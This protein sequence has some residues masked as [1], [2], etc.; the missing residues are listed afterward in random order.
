MREMRGCGA[1]CA[2]KFD[3]FRCI[4]KMVLAPDDM[5]DFHFDVVDHIH[6]VKNPRAVGAADRHIGMGAWIC[7]IEID[8]AADEV[9]DHHVLT[10]RAKTERARI[11][12]NVATILKFLQIA[13][14]NLRSLALQ[15]RSHISNG[16]T[17]LVPIEAKPAQ[18]FIDRS[19]GLFGVA[20]SVGVLDAQNEFAAMMSREEPIK[21]RRARTADMEVTSG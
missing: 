12:E 7:E 9:I 1:E 8:F 15:I 13:F 4:R 16:V 17:T 6:E 20:C 21:K 3:M 19:G 11:F 5:R 18:S 14:V 10:R 2:I